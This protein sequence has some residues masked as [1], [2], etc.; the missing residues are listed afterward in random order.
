VDRA[1]PGGGG[2]A[3]RRGRRGGASA[4][5][6]ARDQA[7]ASLW[8]APIAAAGAPAVEAGEK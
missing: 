5:A 7:A 4:R 2:G 1:V 3:G 8:A 6:R